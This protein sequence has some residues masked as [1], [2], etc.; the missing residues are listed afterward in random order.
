MIAQREK[1]HNSWQRIE[2]AI[3]LNDSECQIYDFNDKNTFAAESCQPKCKM[4]SDGTANMVLEFKLDP[5]YRK[6]IWKPNHYEK[7]LSFALEHLSSKEVED[8]NF[9]SITLD[10]GSLIKQ[11]N[12]LKQAEIDYCHYLGFLLNDI[13]KHFILGD[14]QN[15]SFVIQGLPDC[16]LKDLDLETQTLDLRKKILFDALKE[17][18]QSHKNIIFR[19]I[20]LGS[21]N[22][23]ANLGNLLKVEG[24][25]LSRSYSCKIPGG[26][27]IL[28][29]QKS[30]QADGMLN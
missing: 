15:I 29:L 6:D 2:E 10:I 23:L 25:K 8:A 20:R 26:D 13:N 3:R 30:D 1:I 16:F 5:M 21:T 11:I 18:L 17:I 28:T 19:D 4:N 27:Y 12:Q 9:T 22:S 14:T 24:H 7:R